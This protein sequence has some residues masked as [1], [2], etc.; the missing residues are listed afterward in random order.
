MPCTK[1][2]MHDIMI[3]IYICDC[4]C[5][6]Q[7]SSHQNLNSFFRKNRLKRLKI[8]RG[9]TSKVNYILFNRLLS[10]VPLNK[11]GLVQAKPGNFTLKSLNRCFSNYYQVR[12]WPVFAG[13]VTYTISCMIDVV[14]SLNMHCTLCRFLVN[15]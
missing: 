12:T 13:T 2:C 4:L 6:N 9:T 7:P 15:Q 14:A 11:S 5:K 3:Y 10:M 1:T 8:K